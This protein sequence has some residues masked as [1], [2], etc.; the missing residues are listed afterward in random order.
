MHSFENTFFKDIFA[1]TESLPL[2]KRWTFINFSGAKVVKDCKPR[3]TKVV[4]KPT[5]EDYINRQTGDSSLIRPL[6]SV[7]LF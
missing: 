5:K 6:L 2:S 3:T 7:R 1:I 4:I